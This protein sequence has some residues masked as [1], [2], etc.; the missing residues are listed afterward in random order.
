[1]TAGPAATLIARVDLLP[2]VG[3]EAL[4]LVGAA[5]FDAR[6]IFG[7]EGGRIEG[8]NLR[9]RADPSAA[10]WVVVGPDGVG[11]ID[12]TASLLTDD[13]ARIELR[14]RGAMVLTDDVAVAIERG[15]TTRFEDHHFRVRPRFTTADPRYGWLEGGRFVA[16]GRIHAGAVEWR[17][18]PVH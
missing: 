12:A 2:G 7:W 5:A 6:A 15:G 13:G 18:V 8:A 11:V 14:Y 4:A 9:A 16:D 17:V 3:V 1:M 10:V